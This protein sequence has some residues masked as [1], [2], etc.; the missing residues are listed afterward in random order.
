MQPLCRL[1]VVAQTLM[2]LLRVM[3]LGVSQGS[4]WFL[5][6]GDRYCSLRCH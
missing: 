3:R 6:D 2:L 1:Y 5:E 4:Q